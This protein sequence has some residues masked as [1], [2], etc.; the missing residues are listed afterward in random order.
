MLIPS[1]EERRN[2]NHT[3]HALFACIEVGGEREEMDR[4]LNI[5]TVLAVQC[6]LGSSQSTSSP[7]S[8]R[9]GVAQGWKCFK[10]T[11]PQIP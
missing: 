5:V 7:A 10:C 8:H 11:H 3:D 9:C 1:R 2:D 6:I 4:V